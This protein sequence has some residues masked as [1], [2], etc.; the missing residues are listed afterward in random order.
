[1]LVISRK[2]LRKGLRS[3]QA[4]VSTCL[5]PMGISGGERVG[6]LK[7]TGG[8]RRVTRGSLAAA[9]SSRKKIVSLA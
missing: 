9:P 1:M 8:D 7:F 4:S 2:E 3:V 5:A 6:T